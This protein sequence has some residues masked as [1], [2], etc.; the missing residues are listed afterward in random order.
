MANNDFQPDEEIIDLTELIESSEQPIK[1][2]KAAA[3]YAKTAQTHVADD[4]D[5]DALLADHG[6]DSF[7]SDVNAN[8][9]LDMGKMGD[10]DDLLQ[11]LDI[12]AQ[13]ASLSGD[14]ANA[15]N[16]APAN[17]M[18]NTMPDDLDS[19]LEDILGEPS[20][21]KQAKPSVVESKNTD[22]VPDDFSEN[23]GA[24]LS[25]SNVDNDLDSLLHDLDDMDKP[26]KSASKPVAMPEL[27]AD[28][29]DIL[30]EVTPPETRKTAKSVIPDLPESLD[31]DFEEEGKPEPANPVS[32]TNQQAENN[33]VNATEK[34]ADSNL[35]FTDELDSLMAETSQASPKTPESEVPS[36]MS[37]TEEPAIYN[38]LMS[39]NSL[40]YS[41]EWVAGICKSII[42][43]QG[44]GTQE[45]LQ[46]ISREMGSQTA[47][48]EN[49]G[50]Q[51]SDLTKRLMACEAK[52]SSAKSRMAVLENT[53]SQMN[54]LK[55][56]L[57]EGAP[58]H[59]GLIAIIAK[60]VESA[61]GQFSQD[62][63]KILTAQKTQNS[64]YAALNNKIQEQFN[65]SLNKFENKTNSRISVIEEKI[66]DL[67]NLIAQN[68]QNL[69]TSQ[70]AEK[71]DFENVIEEKFNDH[72]ARI[73]NKF[74][75]RLCELE[76]KVGAL[77]E[78]FNNSIER[79]AASA[80]AKIL[81]EEISRLMEGN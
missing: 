49:I 26:T 52:I 30:S 31:I 41:H 29:D 60:T 75:E 34:L 15:V 54:T 35:G 13:P 70:N 74:D 21:K 61:V 38:P 53:A 65:D 28:L 7:G 55:D 67:G 4:S 11:D 76:G 79:T 58:F 43:L 63:N 17:K 78:E 50:R 64:E 12:P 81:H 56:L 32:Q 33:L 47:N 19:V 73:E 9:E 66:E 59:N 14:T 45:S 16:E 1:P 3:S 20:E 25:S 27:D 51:L 68:S 46:E 71:A 36:T 23:L 80:V 44:T 72:L 37:V 8:E 5:F 24:E 48:I 69:Q 62:I 18:N 40:A 10:I 6:V 77:T 42:S 2:A 57:Q 22:S 39:P